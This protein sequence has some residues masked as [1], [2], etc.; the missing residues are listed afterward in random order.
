MKKAVCAI[1]A[2][3]SF[4][5]TFCTAQPAPSYPTK[6]IRML[7]GFTPGSEIDVVGRMIAH[8][9]SDKWGHKVVVPGFEWDQWYG[10]FAP[11]RTP[12]AIVNQLSREMARVLGLTEIRERLAVRGSVPKPSAP[13]E[14]DRFVRGEVQKV[15]KAIRDGGIKIE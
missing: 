14:F 15:S 1:V 4:A 5:S 12:R 3:C 10:L 11:A 8:E 7:I 9:I 13:E 2:L 6:P